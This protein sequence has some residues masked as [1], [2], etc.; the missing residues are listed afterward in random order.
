MHRTEIL[1]LQP[2]SYRRRLGFSFVET[3]LAILIVSILI[4]I[5]MTIYSRS[6]KYAAK[7]TWRVN[8][9]AR[10]R[11]ALRQ[12]KDFL[13]KSSYPSVVKVAN[14]YES[15]PDFGSDK[16]LMEVKKGKPMAA[17]SSA[18]AYSTFDVPGE[19]LRFHACTPRQELE[20]LGSALNVVPGQAR[21]IVLSLE[22][23]GVTTSSLRLVV[24]SS[25]ADITL[26]GSAVQVGGFGAE[27]SNAMLDDIGQVNVG[28]SRDAAAVEKT[29]L[30]FEV[31]N[32]DPF[33]GRLRVRETAKATVNVRVKQ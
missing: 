9:V 5:T 25:T 21:L 27:T 16:Y 20:G 23:K 31:V 26:G 28:V 11:L 24:T 33:D 1:D 3:T 10:Q 2:A 18:L 8:T 4:S 30:E 14:F 32:V 17:T 13:D 12:I 29:V 7:G 15:S 6:N 22:Q 19:I